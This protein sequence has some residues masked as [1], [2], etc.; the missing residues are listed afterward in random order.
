M[1]S[2]WMN[3]TQC[4]IALCNEWHNLHDLSNKLTRRGE[5]AWRDELKVEKV[6][7]GEREK[8]AMKRARAMLFKWK[9]LRQTVLEKDFRYLCTKVKMHSTYKWMQFLI[10]NG[11]QI[12]ETFSPRL[13]RRGRRR[14]SRNRWCL[15]SSFPLPWHLQHTRRVA[16]RNSIIEVN[17]NS[18]LIALVIDLKSEFQFHL[19]VP[20]Q[21]DLTFLHP[22]TIDT[23]I[24]SQCVHVISSSILCPLLSASLLVFF[25]ASG[26]FI[27]VANKKA[28]K[29]VKHW[30]SPSPCVKLI[31][32]RD[33]VRGCLTE[34]RVIG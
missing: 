34:Q 8:K 30:N 1:K 3:I 2:S 11:E 17:W 6:V 21:F 16:E 5:T 7:D 31:K 15:F 22:F 27:V 4:S 32:H 18:K 20:P 23:F 19:N 10:R 14:R 29:M 13:L 28:Y 25:R 26:C 24:D 12:G 33:L 9:Q